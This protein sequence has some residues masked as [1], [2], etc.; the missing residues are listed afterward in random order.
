MK[1]FYNRL[2]QNKERQL[3]YFICYVHVY[4]HIHAIVLCLMV[5]EK[6][7]H[8]QERIWDY[9]KARS[10]CNLITISQMESEERSNT[11][12]RRS[13]LKLEVIVISDKI[14]GT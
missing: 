8:F 6:C 10:A 13:H 14:L 7:Y 9:V 11:E 2:F 4:T 5:L 1:H 12:S 3:N